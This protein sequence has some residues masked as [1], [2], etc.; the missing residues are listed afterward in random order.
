VFIMAVNATF[1]LNGLIGETAFSLIP[2]LLIVDISVVGGLLAMRR[3]ALAS[4]TQAGTLAVAAS[5]A[6][7]ESSPSRLAASPLADGGLS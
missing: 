3:P 5:S 7:W 2:A 4:M 6:H 1:L